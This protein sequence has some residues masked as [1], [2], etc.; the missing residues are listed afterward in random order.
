MKNILKS[1]SEFQ[2]E[3][4]II[5]KGTQGYGYSFA[6]LPTI[7]PIINPLLKKHGLAYCQPIVGKAVRT[8]LCHLESGETIEA[9][10]DIPQGV[11]L[12]GMNEFQVLGSAI[13]YIRRYA[14]SSMLGIITDKDNDGVGGNA[15]ALDT[16]Q[17]TPQST[18]KKELTKA[19]TKVWQ[20][21][22]TALKEGKSI[23]VVKE[24]YTISVE[25]EKILIE[26]SKK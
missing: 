9:D 13:T 17:P 1:L 24:H 11:S 16:P 8:I 25:N 19:M 21:A 12:K 20:G 7:F 26:E 2:D 10:T 3:C 6:D 18:P 5:H 23:D 4:P 14:L 22:I 15:K